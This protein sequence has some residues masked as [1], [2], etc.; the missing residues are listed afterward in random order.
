MYAGIINV[1]LIC[2]MSRMFAILFADT[3]CH[4]IDLLHTHSQV[5]LYVGEL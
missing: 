1:L 5:L 3:K 4:Q 2:A